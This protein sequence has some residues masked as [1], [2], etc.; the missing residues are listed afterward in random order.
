MEL[1]WRTLKK[2]G[3]KKFE[4]MNVIRKYP[5]SLSFNGYIPED[6]SVLNFRHYYTHSIISLIICHSKQEV[7]ARNGNGWIWIHP[8]TIPMN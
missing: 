2:Y 8:S 7:Y 5:F 4:V 3:M 6:S 1:V